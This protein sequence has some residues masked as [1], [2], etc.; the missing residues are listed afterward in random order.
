MKEPTPRDYRVQTPEGVVLELPLAGAGERCAAFL[1]DALLQLGLLLALMFVMTLMTALAG[2]VGIALAFLAWFLLRHCYFIWF[3]A[4]RQGATPGKRWQQLRVV[5]ADGGPLTI[6]A[7]LARNFMR[8]VETFLPFLFLIAPQQFWPDA[9]GWA[10]LIAGAWL[11]LL[12]LFPLWN[13]E[14]MRV[15][16]L[17]AGTRVIMAPRAVLGRDLAAKATK[18]LEQQSG[19]QFTREQLSIY[20][21]YELQVL[22]QTLRRGRLPGGRQA[23]AAIAASIRTKIGWQPADGLEPDPQAFLTAFYTAQRRHLEQRMLLGERKESKQSGTA[24]R[25]PPPS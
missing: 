10:R 18:H 1:T 25:P 14:R 24:T 22:E 12:L 3:E 17:V 19:I 7:V 9:P 23:L 8:E 6:S 21:I 5:S 15:G 2:G 13:R 4:V 11:F 20:G 16:D